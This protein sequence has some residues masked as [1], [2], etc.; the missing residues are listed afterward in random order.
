MTRRLFRTSLLLGLLFGCSDQGP[1]VPL[2]FV[3]PPTGSNGAGTITSSPGGIS[4]TI[5]NQTSVGACSANFESGAAVTLTA[6][7][8]AGSTFSGWGGECDGTDPTCAV[9]LDANADV[10][11]GFALANPRHFTVTATGTGSGTITSLP[12]G[13][14]CVYSGTATSGTCET[15]FADGAEVTLTA[16]AAVGT[17][18]N[19]WSD[20]CAS[21]A[22]ATSC[23]VTMS[24]DRTAGAEFVSV[25]FGGFMASTS[26]ATTGL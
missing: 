8:A 24:A 25:S 17:G 3:K 13:L 9:T 14:N 20:D 22:G 15:D 10:T 7:P 2:L 5:S 12:G 1:Q 21:S 6:S 16:A 4:C 26:S 19:T 18:F 23:T 11:A